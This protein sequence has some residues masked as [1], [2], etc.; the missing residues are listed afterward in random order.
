[1]RWASFVSEEADLEVAVVQAAQEVRTQLAGR[2]ADLLLVFVSDHHADD[3]GEIPGELRRFFPDSRI[4]GCSGG[5]VVGGGREVEYSPALSL[6]AAWLPEVR[7]EPFYLESQEAEDLSATPAGWYERLQIVGNDPAHFILMPDPFSCD[8]VALLDSLDTAYPDSAKIG[9][10]ASGASRPGE[11]ALIIDDAVYP[12][13][14][15][16]VL[17]DGNID[18][19]TIVAQGCRPIGHPVFITRAARNRI[20]EIDGRR[21]TEVMAELFH[22]LEA[23]DQR[24]FRHSLF[25]GMVMS[26]GLSEYHHG[27]FLI[28]NIVGIDPETGTVAIG[29]VVRP[30]QVMQ[31]HLRDASSSALDLHD[32]LERYGRDHS[33]DPSGVLLFSCLGRGQGLYGEPD[34]DSRLLRDQFGRAP[35]GGFFCGGEIGPVDRRTFVHGYTSSIGVFRPRHR[36]LDD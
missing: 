21:P 10:L 27:D 30:G 29:E 28:R 20:L 2:P 25:V 3:Y 11:N 16:G 32:A 24:L 22:S 31:F 7:V 18:M 19:D 17:L 35:I 23:D 9:G 4:V 15:V 13:G 34:H 6:T 8:A 33:A 36:R 5:G 12:D 26:E 1:M 14:A